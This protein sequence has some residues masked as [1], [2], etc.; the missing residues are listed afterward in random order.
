VFILL[1]PM[2]TNRTILKQM[3]SVY[4]KL[5]RC[6][7]FDIIANVGFHVGKRLLQLWSMVCLCFIIMKCT[8]VLM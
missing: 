1:E 4:F 7:C 3:Y 8:L 5:I 2:M 6:L